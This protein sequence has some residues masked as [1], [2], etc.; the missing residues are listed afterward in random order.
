[1]TYINQLHDE[2]YPHKR[3]SGLENLSWSSTKTEI[4]LEVR[5]Q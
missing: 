4:N 2:H 1:M 3:K 5:V